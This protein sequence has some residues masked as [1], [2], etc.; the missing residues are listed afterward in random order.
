MEMNQD[1][2]GIT[3]GTRLGRLYACELNAIPELRNIGFRNGESYSFGVR[4]F[5][6]KESMDI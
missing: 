1:S 6:F 3:F 4:G 5:H 2:A